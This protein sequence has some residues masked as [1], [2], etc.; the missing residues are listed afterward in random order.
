MDPN[1]YAKNQSIE[2]ESKFKTIQALVSFVLMLLG[3][4]GIAV[5]FFRPS[6]GIRALLEFAT[7]STFNMVLV[8][9]I[10]IS[11]FAFHRYISHVKEQNNKKAGNAPMFFMMLIGV[12]YA[13]RLVTT[14]GF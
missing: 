4:I 9:I 12:Y 5:E 1:K 14:G 10:A 8:G 2:P 6:G 3:L 13:F 11:L 7:D